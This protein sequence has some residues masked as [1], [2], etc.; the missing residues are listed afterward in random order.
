MLARA[1]VL[2]GHV[3]DTVG[4]DG[5]R[6][7][8]LRDAPQRPA[9]AGQA[10]ATQRLVAAGDLPLALQ[11]VDVHRGLEI[12]GSG[13]HL[14]ALYGQSG[15]A[16]DDPG[17]HVPHGLNAQRKG[18]YIQKQQAL[19]LTG[20]HARLQTR[21]HGYALVRVDVLAGF[22]AGQPLD[23]R[24]YGWDAGR[25]AHQQYPAQ[26]ARLKARV[27]QRLLHRAH[28]GLHQM[29]SQ[30][31]ELGP[32][33]VDLQ[34]LCPVRAG[35]QER[36]ADGGSHGRAQLDLSLFRRLPNAAHG[37]LIMG[38]VDMLPAAEFLHQIIGYAG[39]EIVAAQPV[40]ARRGQHFDHFVVDVQNGHVEGAAAQIVHHDALGTALVHA[41][42]Q[43]RGG[44]LIDD[45]QHVQSGDA[46]RVL[47]GLP[48]TVAE[49]GG[50]GDDRVRDGLA[51]IGLRV[52]LELLQDHGGNFL[53]RIFLAVDVY[54]V[55]RTH[56]PLDGKNG[57]GSVGHGLPLGRRAYDALPAFGKGYHGRGRPS[58]L[59]IGDDHGFAVF[60][61]R[62]AGVCGAK[63]NTDQ[64]AHRRK[65]S[66][67]KVLSYHNL[68]F[69]K[70]RSVKM[71]KP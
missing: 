6:D 38:Q 22:L 17:E 30:L 59:R 43:R 67:P 37:G 34:M 68:Y 48:L 18:R 47:G 46:A 23:R 2:G 1:Q 35:G 57:A 19:D 58:A 54:P 27:L 71:K 65:D 3:Y 66:F 32:G 42:G 64:S 41:V 13:K 4:V 39:V 15:I 20:Q 40:V 9:D 24:L 49:I 53:G 70:K 63:V 55:I 62:N 44:R 25:A 60:H 5:E 12:G 31:V 29:G 51:Q 14:T 50:H 26:I 56:L 61:R 8:D 10:E 21:A 16:V 45:A 28:G 69:R 52:L 36:Q 33:Q 7:L 11:N